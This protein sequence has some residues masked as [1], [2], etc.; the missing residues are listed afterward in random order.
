VRPQ[1]IGGL[2]LGSETCLGGRLSRRQGLQWQPF[3]NRDC[4]QCAAHG[5]RQKARAVSSIAES[6]QPPSVQGGSDSRN[7]SGAPRSC[8][9]DQG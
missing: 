5:S 9:G 1:R 2:R 8:S 7:R 6:V 3:C 4:M